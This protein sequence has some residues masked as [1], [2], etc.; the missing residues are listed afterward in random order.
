MQLPVPGHTR[1]ALAPLLVSTRQ[2]VKVS[3][4]CTQQ[5]SSLHTA[6]LPNKHASSIELHEYIHIVSQQMGTFTM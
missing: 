1:L 5:A 3:A 4:Q 2:S 6:E